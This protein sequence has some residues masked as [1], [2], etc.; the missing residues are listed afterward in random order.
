MTPGDGDGA[1]VEEAEAAGVGGPDWAPEDDGETAADGDTLC[2]LGV[3]SVVEAGDVV[4]DV[5]EGLA[6]A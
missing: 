4:A 3:V 1:A 2:A 6:A 5:G